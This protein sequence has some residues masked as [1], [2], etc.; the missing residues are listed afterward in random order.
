MRRFVLFLILIS[1][2]PAAAQNGAIRLRPPGGGSIGF[3]FQNSSIANWSGQYANEM[4][5]LQ[6]TIARTPIPPANK[7]A[8]V[9]AA[10]V[11][12]SKANDLNQLVLRGA[13]RERIHQAHRDCD[14]QA[15]NLIAMIQRSGVVSR[16]IAQAVARVQ[17]A[18]SQLGHSLFGNGND[19]AIWRRHVTKMAHILEEQADELRAVAGESLTVYDRNLDRSIRNFAHGCSGVERNLIA[20]ASRDKI[21]SD[22]A[23]LNNRWQQ[24]VAGLKS[25]VTANATVRAQA[26]RVDA[27]LGQLLATAQGNNGAIIPPNPGFGYLTKSSAFAVGAGEGGG[28]RVRVFMD[29]TGN[30]SIDFMAYDP[31]FRGGVRVALAD[32]NGDGIPDIVTAPGPGMAP[33]VRVFDGRTLGLL[34][35][36]LAYDPKW[37]NGVHIAAADLSRNGVAM[38]ATG[39][40]GGGGPHVRIFDLAAGKVIDQFFP[41]PEKF[42]GGVR[43][44]MGDVNGD[45]IPD[46]VTA[47]GPIPPGGFSTGSLVKVYDGRNRRVITEFHAYDPRWQNGVWIATGD[48]TRDGRAEIVTGADAGGGPHVRVFEGTNGRFLTDFFP[49]PREF[50]GGVRVAAHD[51]NGDGVLD[52]LCA[53]GPFAGRIPPAVRVFDGRSKRPMTEFTPF[54][55]SFRGGIYVG[56]K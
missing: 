6:S 32:L 7:N 30:Q 22:I 38:I 39:A 41:Y 14:T 51:I 15:S 56:S 25:S 8:L 9:Q 33:L 37:V 42:L 52:F 3:Q 12:V 2:A 46:L 49:F 34:T 5:M 19:E 24:V 28:P 11:A 36:F 17:Y 13:S 10:N 29:L 31:S 54:E 43:V 18:D 1:A 44:A 47:P 53:P 16:E 20:G 27:L 23:E 21:N 35:E 4:A 50:T 55:P 40:D 48:I 26:T 45:G